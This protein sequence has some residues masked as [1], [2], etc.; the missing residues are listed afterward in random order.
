VADGALAEGSI[1][2]PVEIPAKPTVFRVVAE[3]RVANLVRRHEAIIDTRSSE[4]PLL[5]SWRRLR[6]SD[7][8]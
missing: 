3:A 8:Q 1:F 4:G 2:P 5:L 6:G 7:A